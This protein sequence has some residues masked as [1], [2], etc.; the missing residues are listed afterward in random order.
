MIAILLEVVM[1]RNWG[2]TYWSGCSGVDLA[3][4]TES[5]ELL[6]TAISHL[7]SILK[8]CGLIIS[9]LFSLPTSRP[10]S[11]NHHI[12]VYGA[13]GYLESILCLA[14]MMEWSS[15]M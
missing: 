1:V 7:V 13:Q 5:I 2:P 8:P 12:G 9:S 6:G 10:G 15:A 4:D 3:E 14:L 11:K